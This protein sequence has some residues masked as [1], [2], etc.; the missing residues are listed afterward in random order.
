MDVGYGF[1][2]FSRPLSHLVMYFEK[3]CNNHHSSA[4]V[5]KSRYTNTLVSNTS[6]FAISCS[7][8]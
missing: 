3:L 2:F 6:T 1:F 8:G 4:N 5:N 7:N